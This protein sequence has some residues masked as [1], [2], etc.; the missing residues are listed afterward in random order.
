MKENEMNT[1]ITMP[2]ISYPVKNYVAAAVGVRLWQGHDF[3]PIDVLVE[4]VR[5]LMTRDGRKYPT[6]FPKR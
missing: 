5:S 6:I 4:L 1:V 2:A 3:T